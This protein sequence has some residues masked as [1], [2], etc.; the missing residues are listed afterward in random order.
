MHVNLFAFDILYFNEPITHLSLR[1][2]REY[3]AKLQPILSSDILRIS[4][5]SEVE[6]FEKIDEFLS[7]AIK[8]GTEGLMIKDLDSPY[9]CSRRSW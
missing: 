7:S 9:T 2:R 4:E 8:F 1:E 6:D 3:L 5:H